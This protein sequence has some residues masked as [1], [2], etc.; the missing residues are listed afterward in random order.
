LPRGKYKV[1]ANIPFTITAAI[2][3]KLTSGDNPPEDTYLILQKEAAYKF[4]G[5][6]I[7]KTTQYS[8]LLKP[9]FEIKVIHKLRRTDFRPIPKVDSVLLRIKKREKPLVPVVQ[10]Q[11]YRDFV[12][13]G[14][15]QW[16]PTL[17]EA[18]NKI[19]TDKQFSKLA[20]NLG[21]SKSDKP[22]E[23]DFGKWLGLFNYLAEHVQEDKQQIVH[24]AEKRLKKQ[25]AGLRKIHR[26]GIR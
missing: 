3:G 9:W 7:G 15:N 6:P 21:F 11:L 18:M 22:T 25:Q 20:N 23:L 12:V 2:I 13:Y 16:K 8:L 14:F 10:T 24:G 17:R 4:V 5:K 1:F 26:T 19:F